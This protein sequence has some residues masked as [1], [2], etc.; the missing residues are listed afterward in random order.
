MPRAGFGGL[1]DDTL[2]LVELPSLEKDGLVWVRP[3]VGEAIDADML[4]AG[5]APEIASYGFEGY[6]HYETRTLTKRMNWKLVIDTFLETWHVGTLHKETVAPI[7]QPNVNVFDAFGPH[8][9]LII[10]RRSI[11]RLR[12]EP[13]ADW[14]FLR[15][16]AVIYVLFPHTLL[17]WQGDHLEVWRSYPGERPDETTAEISFYVPKPVT[18]EKEGEHWERNMEIL[19]LTVNEEDF[20]VCLD[21]QKNFA[22]G[23]QDHLT[24]GRNEPALSHYHRGVRRHIGVHELP[25]PEPETSLIP[26]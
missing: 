24:F 23:A 19:M 14:D 4:L 7:F 22:S 15:H 21:I 16:S 18:S 5:L 2:N 10:P 20:P 6:S 8:G 26:A 12:E 1:P 11:L 3:S 9:R 25:Q 17:V 13:E